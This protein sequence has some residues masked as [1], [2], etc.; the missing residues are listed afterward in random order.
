MKDVR[1]YLAEFIGTFVLVFVAATRLAGYD[2]FLVAQSA[3]DLISA[4]LALVLF[5]GA[6]GR[7]ALKERT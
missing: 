3:A 6:F 4:V 1:K 5:H 2:G 7:A